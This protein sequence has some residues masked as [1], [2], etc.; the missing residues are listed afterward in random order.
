MHYSWVV[1]AVS[2]IVGA[3][4]IVFGISTYGTNNG[5][6][7]PYSA[8]VRGFREAFINAT[9][10]FQ[11]YPDQV[12]AAFEKYHLDL[13][14]ALAFRPLASE[15]TDIYG[16]ILMFFNVVSTVGDWRP[17]VVDPGLSKYL[18]F[19]TVALVSFWT[20]VT[21][22]SYHLL[23]L[24]RHLYED[25]LSPQSCFPRVQRMKYD[26]NAHT[27]VYWPNIFP[28]YTYT[29]TS[30]SEKRGKV[31]V[32]RL[33]EDELRVGDVL[34]ELVQE[35]LGATLV[36]GARVEAQRDP[37]AAFGLQRLVQLRLRAADGQDRRLRGVDDG[38]EL[39]DAEHAQVGHGEGAAL[40]FVQLQLVRLGSRCELPESCAD[41]QDSQTVR[42]SDD[43][44]DETGGRRDGH[45]HVYVLQTLHGAGCRVAHVDLWDHPKR[46]GDR[47]DDEVVQGHLRPLR[48][49]QLC[50]Q[51][52]ETVS[53]DGYGNVG[54]RD[55]LLG[56]GESLGDRRADVRQRDVGELRS[57]SLA[58]EQL[59]GRR[60]CGS[61]GYGRRGCFRS[62]D[63]DRL[64]LSHFDE[65][66]HV[67]LED[68]VLGARA[69]DGA[70]VDHV[71]L[72]EKFRGGARQA[73]GGGG[74]PRSLQAKEPGGRKA[75]LHLKDDVV[76]RAWRLGISASCNA[77]HGILW[78]RLKDRRVDF[79]EEIEQT[80][81]TFSN[82]H[83]DITCQC[84][85]TTVR[86]RRSRHSG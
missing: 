23:L 4:C 62:C 79:F 57:R 76:C 34:R 17:I 73:G 13:V 35:A 21:I 41:L 30:R 65:A 45:R 59:P 50:S 85:A 51:F 16:T 80:C 60:S 44:S 48:G 3:I 68:V 32:G 63:G 31:E 5:T 43:G 20:A 6:L 19:W 36:D 10:E 22:G 42:L 81:T 7:L 25:P 47:L 49:V 29:L 67:G 55:G 56:G 9:V 38:G 39:R 8:I 71:V 58:E 24:L 70:F 54:V 78:E 11:S 40:E 2:T 77:S 86:P 15:S 72:H 14:G 18:V 66:Q 33:R 84:S 64:Q 83:V 26:K 69:R 52:H 28:L 75:G 74:V 61:L 1:A 37:E 82:A 12:A 27:R 53:L 46:G